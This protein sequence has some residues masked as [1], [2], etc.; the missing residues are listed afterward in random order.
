MLALAHRTYLIAKL[1]EVR[2][3]YENDPAKLVLIDSLINQLVMARSGPAYHFAIMS[4]M[5][6]AEVIPELKEL[7]G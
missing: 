7:V 3:K 4:L 5:E 6:A 1:Y 2:K